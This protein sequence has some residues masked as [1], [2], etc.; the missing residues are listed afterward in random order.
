M[1]WP[2][3]PRPPCPQTV[4]PVHC[5]TSDSLAYQRKLRCALSSWLLVHNVTWY[6]CR[7]C[8]GFNSILE[9]RGWIVWYSASVGSRPNL[10]ERS[11]SHPEDIQGGPYIMG[12]SRQV[13]LLSLIFYLC[14]TLLWSVDCAYGKVNFLVS[15]PRLTISIFGIIV[16]NMLL[17]LQLKSCCII[18]IPA[19]F[20][21]RLIQL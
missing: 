20:S 15:F 12:N 18:H 14:S 9:T 21:I 2:S 19:K 4:I 7:N 1:T 11:D 3:D 6:L 13:R 16:N 5:W 8:Q 10:A 17:D